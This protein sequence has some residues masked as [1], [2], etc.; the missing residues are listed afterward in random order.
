MIV[1]VPKEIKPDEYRVGLLP[2]GA[3]ELTRAGHQVLV[4]SA[5]GVGSGL[6]DEDYPAT[7]PNWSPARKRSTAGPTWCSRSR[8]RSPPSCGCCGRARSSS[9]IST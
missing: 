1:G 7:A 3:E 8:S 2:V 9:P 6:T 5:A 4:E